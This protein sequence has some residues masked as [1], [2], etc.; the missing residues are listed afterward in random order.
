M[1]DFYLCT[2]SLASFN[3]DYDSSFDILEQFIGSDLHVASFKRL[4]GTV[5]LALL[6][7]TAI[8]GSQ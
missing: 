3:E 4:A 8:N 6:E 2:A 7:S 1:L 5:V